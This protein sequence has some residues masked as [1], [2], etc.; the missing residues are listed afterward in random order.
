MIKNF[1]RANIL[2]PNNTKLGI[3][4]VLYSLESRKKLP[5]FKYTR[6]DGYYI[7]IIDE[8]KKN[9]FILFHVF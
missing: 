9:I 8:K 5:N 6:A 1:K 2:L 3:K 7:E 4:Y